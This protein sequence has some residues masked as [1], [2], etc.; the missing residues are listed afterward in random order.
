MSIQ[1][2]V[3]TLEDKSQNQSALQ[4]PDDDLED[5][6]IYYGLKADPN[7]IEAQMRDHGVSWSDFF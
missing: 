3:F 4:S 2:E 6:L 5:M 7:S 1:K